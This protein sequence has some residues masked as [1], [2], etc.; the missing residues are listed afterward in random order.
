MKILPIDPDRP[1]KGPLEAA[2]RLLREG[3]IVAFPTETVYGLGGN[4]LDPAVVHKIF[5]AKGRPS[6]NPLIAHVVDS[7][8]AAAL[9]AEWPEQ[10]Q[11]LA[12]RFWP[13][14]LTMVVPKTPTVPDV[15]TAG[16]STVAIRVPRH[17]VAQALLKLL[18][19]PL[20]APSANRYTQLSPT[21]GR[22]VVKGLAGRIDLVL[23]AGPTPVG[24]E[25]TVVDLSGHAPVLLRPGS[26][27]AGEIED[28][29]GVATGAPRSFDGEEARPAPGNVRRHYS[30]QARVVLAR[31]EELAERVASLSGA[32]GSIGVI[33]IDEIAPSDADRI[34]VLG[35]AP[36]EF[37]R[38]LY[39]ALHELD[40]LGVAAIV[41]QAPPEDPAWNAVRDRL[42][43]AADDSATPG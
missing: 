6:F 27:T 12:E 1:E 19:F 28:V 37:A 8:A 30:P 21:H 38:G 24:I 18:P 22:H 35:S 11:R 34:I 2:A 13:G 43:R 5:A 7:D 25:S 3:G 23:D 26:I 41:V 16:L 9:S 15:V 14:P 31:P 20:A 29:L 4:A 36:A 40:E 39:S 42:S 32:G 17:P 10:A 33:G